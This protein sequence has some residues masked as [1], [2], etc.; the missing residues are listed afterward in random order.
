MEI[1]TLD[2]YEDFASTLLMVKIASEKEVGNVIDLMQVIK[3]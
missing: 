2:N 1:E 3:Y